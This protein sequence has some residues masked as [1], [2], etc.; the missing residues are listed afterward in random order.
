VRTL[1]RAD[2]LAPHE[3]EIWF[4]IAAAEKARGDADAARAAVARALA[5]LPVTD[6][7][8]ARAAALMSDP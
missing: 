2:R 8:R 7:L 5:L 1:R 3:G 6:P 4:H